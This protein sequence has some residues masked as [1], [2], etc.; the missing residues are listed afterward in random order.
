MTHLSSCESRLL[1]NNFMNSKESCIQ[2]L[3]YERVTTAGFGTFVLML[4]APPDAAPEGFVSPGNELRIGHL[5]KQ[6]H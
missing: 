4:D 1:T 2:L 3:A 5:S 6:L